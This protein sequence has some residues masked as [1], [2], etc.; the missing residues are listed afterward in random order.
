MI[1]LLETV[2]AILNASGMIATE[3]YGPKALWVQ[4]VLDR[5]KIPDCVAY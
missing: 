5:Q 1:I 3:I 2:Q 4:K